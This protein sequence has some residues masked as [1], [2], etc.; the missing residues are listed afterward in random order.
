MLTSAVM[1]DISPSSFI[2][3]D[4]VD[5]REDRRR[6]GPSRN[7][8]PRRG[9]I[10]PPTCRRT[11][12]NTFL[13]LNFGTTFAERSSGG[14]MPKSA[15][16]AFMFFENVAILYLEGRT[17]ASAHWARFIGKPHERKPIGRV[18]S[19]SAMGRDGGACAA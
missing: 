7:P 11:R 16:G 17:I 15:I 12:R 4:P 2:S 13:F 14:K 6:P 10:H 1:P 8:G 5:G 9:R 19:S 3:H 18:G